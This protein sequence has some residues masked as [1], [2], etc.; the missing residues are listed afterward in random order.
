MEEHERRSPCIPDSYPHA[1]DVQYHKR[2]DYG[3]A[4][5]RGFYF[6]TGKFFL[7][8]KAIY[9]SI[10]VRSHEATDEEALVTNQD[11]SSYGSTSA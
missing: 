3:F 11:G 2:Y 7:D 4:G 1:I 6:T 5:F 10:T 8:A 9:Q